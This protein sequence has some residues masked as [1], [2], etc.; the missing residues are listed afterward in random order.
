MR[1]VA[2]VYLSLAVTIVGAGVA[3]QHSDSDRSQAGSGAGMAKPHAGSAVTASTTTTPK[4]I[5]QIPPPVD[6]KTPPADAV[7]TA[8]GLVYKKLVT[9]GDG[10]AIGRND[11]VLINSTTWKQATGETIATNKT[12]GQPLPFSLATAAPGFTEMM[13]LLRKGEKAVVWVPPGVPFR[14]QPSPSAD[15]MVYMIEVVD[16]TPA[17]AIPPDVAAPPPKALAFK[18]GTKY[19]IVRAGTGTDK[20]RAWDTVTFNYSAWDAD[21]HMFDTTETRKRAMTAPP[22]RQSAVLEEVLTSV[23]AGT[24]VR[25]W[26]DSEKMA[27]GGHP[28]PNMP[29]GQLCY[30]VELLQIAKAA[31][32]PPP[33]PSDVAKPPSDAQKTAKGVFFKLLKAGPG[34]AKPKANDVVKVNYTGWTTDGRMFDSSLLRANPAEFSLMGVIQGWGDGIPTMSV[35][36]KTRFWIPEELAYKGA[37]NRPQGMLVFDVELLEIKQPPAPQGKPPTVP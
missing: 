21:G 9:N 3:C 13:Q 22:F 14:A 4:K 34:G 2:A 15:E 36:D 7:K 20:A 37:P 35:G 5:E 26:A 6:L 18:S 17:P 24:R 16:V 28:L 33:P 1:A 8:S 11:S 30:E 12:R 10:T 25:F 32:D 19:E 27:Q 31:N 23:T 29:K